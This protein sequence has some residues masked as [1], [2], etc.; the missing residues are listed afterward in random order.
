M[1]LEITFEVLNLANVAKIYLKYVLKIKFYC[2]NMI[3]ILNRPNIKTKLSLFKKKN[4]IV[5][6]H[7][8]KVVLNF[9]LF[10]LI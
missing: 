4:K 1:L 8:L 10:I 5:K 7:H 9:Y 3:L 6:E 2:I